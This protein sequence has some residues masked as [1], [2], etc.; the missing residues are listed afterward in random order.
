MYCVIALRNAILRQNMTNKRG[1]QALDAEDTLPRAKMPR[2]GPWG[3]DDMPL[4]RGG[5]PIALEQAPLKEHGGPASTSACMTWSITRRQG[6][7]RFL[8]GRPQGS[9]A[10]SCAGAKRLRQNP[11]RVA[12]KLIPR[13]SRW[14]RA[15]QGPGRLWATRAEAL[16]LS[17]DPGK[18]RKR[19]GPLT[20][21]AHAL[22][23]L[24]HPRCTPRS[25]G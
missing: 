17:A 8:E 7:F 5:Q 6:P 14:G 18:G 22:R 13:G 16:G 2:N 21:S 20:H 12:F 19:R 10:S 9:G 1:E 3:D 15:E 4:R 11:R 24:W 23:R 25:P